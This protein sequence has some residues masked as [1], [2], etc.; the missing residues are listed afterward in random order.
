MN[1]KAGNVRW[2][3]GGLIGLGVIVNY[4]D[5]VNISVATHPMMNQFH[6][7]LGRVGILLSAF[8]WSYTVM[9]IPIGSIL[10]R[11][12]IKWLNRIGIILWSLATM[13]TAVAGGMGIVI[14]SRVLLGI[15]ECPAFPGASKATGYWFPLRERG[16]ATSLFDGAAKI[17]NVL[18]IPLVAWTMTMWGWRGGFWFTAILSLVFAVVWWI[19]YRDPEEHKKITKEEL[20][21]IKEGGAQETGAPEDGVLRSLGFLLTQR[22]VLALT[23][24]FAAYGY[25]FGLLSSW[26][27]GYLETQMHMSLLKTGAYSVV[28]WIVASVADV[29]IGG[30]LVDKV[31]RSGRDASK[32][33]KT[34]MAIGMILGLTVGLAGFTKNPIIA[35]IWITISLAGLSMF[36]PIGWSLP[37][38]VAPKGTVGIVGGIMNFLNGFVGI[39]STILTGYVAQAS[40]SFAGPFIL[41][42]CVLVVG[43]F[44]YTVVMGRIEQIQ[45]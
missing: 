27:P 35:I 4:F 12:G 26:I 36:A 10:D 42:A 1:G 20:E 37:S 33:R 38:I 34:F 8:S 22:K 7:S 18:G 21:Y 39:V 15:A 28:P 41:A 29:F 25:A 19:W 9:Q 13:L 2:S 30:W 43:I 5:R 45:R 31:I 24:G 11:I 23:F 32:V 3:I 40:H 16:L 44:F 6:L 17:S 14:L